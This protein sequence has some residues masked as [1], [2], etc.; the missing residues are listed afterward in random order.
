MILILYAALLNFSMKIFFN[1]T[2]NFPVFL[3]G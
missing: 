1:I 3:D 2:L